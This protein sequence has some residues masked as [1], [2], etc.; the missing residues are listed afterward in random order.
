MRA[1]TP[2]DLLRKSKPQG[3]SYVERLLVAHRCS[4]TVMPGVARKVGMH[5]TDETG[6]RVDGWGVAGGRRAGRCGGE[7]GLVGEGV[8][9]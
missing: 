4:G 6:V 3:V 1:G 8:R 9:E 2:A 5:E 7:D